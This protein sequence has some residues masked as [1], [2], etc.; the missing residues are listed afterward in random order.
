VLSLVHK[1]ISK[2]DLV[3]CSLGLLM[4]LK[5][6]PMLAGL[7]GPPLGNAREQREAMAK[8]PRQRSAVSQTREKEKEG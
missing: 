1:D 7:K 4:T 6:E 5:E 8:M 2:G 3:R